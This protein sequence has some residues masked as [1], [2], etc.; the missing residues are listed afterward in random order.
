M[1]AML[2]K[3]I[4]VYEPVNVGDRVR[5]E[6]RE[7]SVGSGIR[8]L[9]VDTSKPDA[10]KNLLEILSELFPSVPVKTFSKQK[11][12]YMPSFYWQK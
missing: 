7:E 1:Q 5:V 10:Y 6:F 8:A 11:H 2:P 12:S 9:V 3:K 4:Y